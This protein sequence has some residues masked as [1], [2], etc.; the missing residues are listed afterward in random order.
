MSEIIADARARTERAAAMQREVAVEQQKVAVEMQKA[1]ME[2]QKATAELQAT[3]AR[4]E[5]QWAKEEI[6][7]RKTNE[8]NERMLQEILADLR[9][10]R[11]E[12]RALMEALFRV[13]DRLDQQPPPPPNLRSA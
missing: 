2:Q 8:R 3:T 13:M 4:L 1:T 7:M 5:K 6:V 11:D 9:E 10:Q 12:R